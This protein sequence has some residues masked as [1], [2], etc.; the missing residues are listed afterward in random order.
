MPGHRAQKKV[1]RHRSI[2]SLKQYDLTDAVT[3]G[4]SLSV[5][6]VRILRPGRN[7]GNALPLVF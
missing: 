7:L 6:D 5:A 3:R 1:P 2:E 4:G